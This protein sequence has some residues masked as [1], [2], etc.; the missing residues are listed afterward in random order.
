MADDRERWALIL[1]ASSG[2]GEAAGLALA[3]AGYRIFGIHLD[4]RA[5]LAHVEEVKASIAA[6]GSEAIFI[7]MNAADDEKRAAAIARF[8][9]RLEASRAAGKRPHLR[10]VMHSLAFGSKV[11]AMTSEGSARMIPSY[12][13]VSAAKAALESHC[14]H[15]AMELA[16]LHSGVAVNAIR[17]G[18]TDT[19][20]LRKIPEAARV[21]E[22][23]M[24]R[25]PHG[26][27]TTV[28]DVAN[29]LVTLASTDSDW[30]SGNVIN[31]DG[32]EFISG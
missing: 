19:P 28:E 13:A 29:A 6:T 18:V 25:N 21:I 10:V 7:N 9:E 32:G 26:R 1:G 3:R 31:V 12:G 30:I 16:R 24:G 20:A 8:S 5:G 11:F 22:V 17:A 4:F 2:M 15:L 23:T 27:L 14:R